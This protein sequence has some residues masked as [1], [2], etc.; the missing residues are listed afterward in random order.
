MVFEVDCITFRDHSKK[1]GIYE[2]TYKNHDFWRQEPAGDIIKDKGYVYSTK[3][4]PCLDIDKKPKKKDEINKHQLDTFEKIINVCNDNNCEMLV[5][6]L[7]SLTSWSKK[8]TEQVKEICDKYNI[9]FIDFNKYDD[10]DQIVEI[11]YD[12]DYRDG[13]NHLNLNGAIKITN[14]LSD[15]IK[16]NFEIE[17]NKLNTKSFEDAYKRFERKL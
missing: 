4:K 13:G 16:N 7:P 15:Y 2:R 8:R 14:Y 6:E 3:V 1:A 12:K 11:D 5:I 9:N 17:A 10:E